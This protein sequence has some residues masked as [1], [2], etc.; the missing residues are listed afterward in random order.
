MAVRRASTEK[1]TVTGGAGAR[2]VLIAALVLSAVGDS[3]AALALVLQAASSA[4]SWW[5]TQAFLAELLPPV[6]LAPLLGALVDRFAARTVWMVSLVGQI[7]A[8]L[9]ASVSAGYY[10][11]L[12]YATVVAVLGVAASA[13][14]FKLLPERLGDGDAGRGNGYIVAG[15]SFA[16]LLGPALG[17]VGYETL[18]GG[19]LFAV[20]GLS[21]TLILLAIAVLL[22]V[23]ARRA[24]VQSLSLSSAM[25]GGRLLAGRG[26]LRSMF[27]LVAVIIVSTSLEGVA[28]VFY[29]RDV[30]GGNTVYG[31]LLAAWAVGSIPG[32]FVGGRG[33]LAQRPGAS[34]T[35]GGGLVG[36]AL[37]VEG[38]VPNATA[39][40]I[41]FLVGGFGNAI[42]N[43]AIRNAIGLHV[44]S[45]KQGRAWAAFSV[46]GNTCIATGYVA[47][48]PGIILGA[49]GVVLL[50]GS[51]ATAAVIAAI[52]SG[53]IRK[54][55][56]SSTYVSGAGK[57]LPK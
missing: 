11:R 27:G 38:L 57:F 22:P 34:A 15:Q 42:L 7:V 45:D 18:G 1:A 28:G 21:F 3:V 36:L 37:L 14:A 4:H 2:G 24:E 19:V 32:S 26:P 48:T 5:V 49:R 12:S 31:I 35:V 29:L 23:E 56:D 13:A 40:G 10:S 44:P 43:V 47:G 30:A 52:A 25:E 53:T 39:I 6:A 9:G 55:S 33:R 8:C 50:S 17:G 54:S 46:L 20:N 16:F 51:I 41:V